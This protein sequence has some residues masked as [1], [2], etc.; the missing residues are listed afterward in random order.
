MNEQ[1]ESRPT[2]GFWIVAI[3]ALIWNLIGVMTYLMSVTMSPEMLAEMTEAERALYTG[4][5]AWAT[6]AYAIAVFGGVL[7]CISL[8]LR[9]SWAVPL[10]AVSLVG[11]IVQM[12]YG[13]GMTDVLEVR[14]GGALVMPIVIFAIAAYLLWFSIISKKQGWLR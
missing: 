1:A 6:S 10:F 4:I 13:L 3:V 12:S 8:L 2:R 11:V 7:G 9:R 14:G 5:P